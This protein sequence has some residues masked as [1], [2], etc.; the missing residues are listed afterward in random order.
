MDLV[1]HGHI[2][3][4][5]FVLSNK[6]KELPKNLSSDLTLINGSLKQVLKIIHDKGYFK[7]YI[8]GGK[9]VQNFLKEDLIDELR[10][11]TIPIILGG[12]QEKTYSNINE[13]RKEKKE[14]MVIMIQQIIYSELNLQKEIKKFKEIGE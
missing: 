2:V 5:V 10:I 8:G 11:T 7:L 12:C 1:E 6:L 3:N 9:T 14:L 13:R 4:H